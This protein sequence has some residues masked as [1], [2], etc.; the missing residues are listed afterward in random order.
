MNI[1]LTQL[2]THL[3]LVGRRLNVIGPDASAYTFLI[4]SYLAEAAIKTL[5]VVFYT[6]LTGRSSTDAYRLGYDL[7]RADGLGAWEQIIREST[8]PLAS[9][10]PADFNPLLAWATRK[11][12]KPEDLPFREARDQA[13]NVLN[14]LGQDLSQ[15]DV[16]K[17]VTILGLIT[18]L[19]QIRNKTKAHGAVG[20]DFF[21][22]SNQAYI[23][24][25]RVL[26]D[27]CPAFAWRWLHL[28]VR[29]KGSVRAIVLGGDNP[30]HLRA[31]ESSGI[32]VRRPGVHFQTDNQTYSCADLL[33]TNLECTEFLLPNGGYRDRRAEFI[34]YGN[35]QTYD[36]DVHQF[37]LP[38]APLPPSETEGMPILDVQSNLFGNLPAVPQGY[39]LRRELQRNLRERLLDRNHPIITLHGQGGVGKTSLALFVAHD[40]AA[41][42]EPHFEHIVWFSARDIDLRPRGPSRV[43]PAILDLNAVSKAFAALF[44]GEGG[45]D[46][47]AKDLRLVPPGVSRGNLYIFDNF[48]TLLDP[49][50]L[51]EFLDTHTHLPNKV[52][53]TSRERAF[54]ADYP[55]EVRGMEREEAEEMMRGVARALHIGGLVTSEVIDRIYQYTGGHAYVMRVIIGEIAKEGRYV[56]PKSMMA[57][58]IDIAEAVF[59]R[60]F[61][62]LSPAGRFVFLTVANSKSIISEVA[63]QGVLGLRDLDVRVGIEECQRLSLITEDLMQDRQPCYWAPHLAR[64]FGRKKLEGDPDRLQVQEDL[65][66]LRQFGFIEPS[67]QTVRTLDDQIKPF[68]D[69]CMDNEGRDAGRKA[70]LDKHLEVL[71]ELWAPGWLML[72]DFRKRCEAEPAQIESALRRAVEEM[73]GN[74]VAWLARASYAE[75]RRDDATRIAALISAV[76]A[77]RSDVALIRDVAHEVCKYVYNHR[78]DIPLNRRGVYLASI[79]SHTVRVAPMLDA[80]GL[81]R[82]AW[83]LSLGEQRNRGPA[84]CYGRS[85]EGSRQR[86]LLENTGSSERIGLSAMI[87]KTWERK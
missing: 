25:V 55:I 80:T 73:P 78:A 62:R 39:V 17:Q 52:L 29:D 85:K 68:L 26:L 87:A 37:D 34:D 64:I 65:E 74:K 38:P 82:L 70:Q 81:S 66:L 19:V 76:D 4:A 44:G 28:S 49:S 60:S 12:T 20:P 46:R 9:F 61:D 27:D 69:W 14:A 86:T 15:N 22:Q 71:S 56:P 31:A 47:F 2:P 13:A 42:A 67:Q 6:G 35:G 54:K 3:A 21:A 30:R 84:L 32:T 75:L 77:A 8:R 53:I 23:A 11:R 45:V 5:A 18:Y 1:D 48:E 50:G 57:A 58:R 33:R 63:I 40:L 59:Q 79:R 51:H 16:Q 24:A 83:L 41:D 7:V 43:R 72:A 10:L 36:E